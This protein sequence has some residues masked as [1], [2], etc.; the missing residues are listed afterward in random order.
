MV[1]S[2]Q[3]SGTQLVLQRLLV[4]AAIVH[5]TLHCNFIYSRGH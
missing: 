4:M 5:D 2:K 1:L 3:S